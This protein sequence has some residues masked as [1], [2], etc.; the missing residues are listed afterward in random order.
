MPSAADKTTFSM[1]AGVF[2]NYTGLGV[3]FAHRFDTELPFAIDGSYSH[4]AGEDLGR[5][6][7]SVDS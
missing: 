7:F 6:G 4:S 5:I 1:H 3:S 2:E